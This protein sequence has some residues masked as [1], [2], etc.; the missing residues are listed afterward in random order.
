MSMINAVET[1]QTQAA[2]P[3]LLQHKHQLD[4][5]VGDLQNV[6]MLAAY[7][8][9]FST[10][11]SAAL[12]ATVYSQRRCWAS[13]ATAGG[14]VDQMLQYVTRDLQVCLFPAPATA[15][16]WHSPWMHPLTHPLFHT[17]ARARLQSTCCGLGC[18]WCPTLLPD[19]T[20]AACT[21]PCP[22]RLPLNTTG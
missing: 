7:R 2:A 20:A 3:L 4:P 15:L 17:R 21:W 10:L 14:V 12:A 9:I 16:P 6:S 8:P 22:R 11:A 1:P 19:T 18:P 5:L 13:A